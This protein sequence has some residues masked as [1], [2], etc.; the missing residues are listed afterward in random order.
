MSRKFRKRLEYNFQLFL[1]T[2]KNTQTKIEKFHLLRLI[3]NISA[4]P[5]WVWGMP[6][7]IIRNF[8]NFLSYLE[9]SKN[10]N[11]DPLEI[12]NVEWQSILVTR[13]SNCFFEGK[14]TTSILILARGRSN[15]KDCSIKKSWNGSSCRGYI[16]EEWNFSARGREPKAFWEHLI[17]PSR[18]SPPNDVLVRARVR[19]CY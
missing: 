16:E 15:L 10:F 17:A 18:W 11:R 2:S 3:G 1:W 6:R 13:T 8:S 7:I 14:E 19:S 4:V 9:I 12:D 5:P